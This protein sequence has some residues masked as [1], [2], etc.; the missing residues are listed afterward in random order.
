MKSRMLF[1]LIIAGFSLFSLSCSKRKVE[2]KEGNWRGVLLLDKN[3]STAVLPFNFSYTQDKDGKPSIVITNADEK[4]KIDEITFTGDT[5]K[6]KLPVFKDEI[7]AKLIK[8]D[9]IAGEYIHYGSKGKYGIRFYA[10]Y[11]KTERFEG[12]NKTPAADISGQWEV[13][14]QPGDSDQYMII[15]EFAQK[16]NKLTGTFLTSSG[17]YRYLDGA[18]SGND[19]MLSCVDGSHTLLFKASYTKEGTLEKGTLVGGPTWKEKWRAVRNETTVLPDPEKQSQIKEGVE[20][21]DFSFPGLNK[22]NVSL[23]DKKF[24]G[25][26]VIITIMGSWCPNC[27]DETRL[28]TSLYDIYNPQGLEVIGLSYE[29]KDIDESIPRIQRFKE[30]IGAKYDLLYAGEASNKSIFETLPFLKDFK[31]YPTTIYLDRDHKV[32]KIYTGFTGP[33]TGKY[34]EKLKVEITDYIK[35]LLKTG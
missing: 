29:S 15:G 10:L 34:Y 8:E 13:T 2:L 20:K 33:G 7:S 23:S 16:G 4:L 5:I 19:V 32:K 11:G 35:D 12:A 26:A 24:K 22:K 28:L 25:K 30:Q 9:S 17:D 3:D 27:M 14:V 31:G 18:V 6:I 1:L 21:I